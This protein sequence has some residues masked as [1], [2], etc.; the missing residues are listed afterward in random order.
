M[1]LGNGGESGEDLDTILQSTTKLHGTPVNLNF[2]TKL[3]Q[4]TEKLSP[5]LPA[6]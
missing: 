6:P 2:L 4:L 3:I 1:C 5:Y